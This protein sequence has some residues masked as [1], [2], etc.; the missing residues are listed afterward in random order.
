MRR[1]P[2]GFQKEIKKKKKFTRGH[3]IVIR[4]SKQDDKPSKDDDP[5]QWKIAE[6]K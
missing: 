6:E 5:K 4:E 1:E 2:K 3:S